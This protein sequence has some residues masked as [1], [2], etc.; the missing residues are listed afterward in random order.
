MLCIKDLEIGH[1]RKSLIERFSTIVEEGSIVS[2]VGDNGV[3]KSTLLKSI[4]S[5]ISPVNGSVEVDNRNL[6]HLSVFEI[7]SYISGVYTSFNMKTDLLV[8]DIL[9]LGLYRKSNLFGSISSEEKDFKKKIVE[10]FNLEKWLSYTCQ[11]IS[12]G[13]LQKV[14]IARTFLQD[15]KIILLDEPFAHLD[16]K[17]RFELMEAL[18]N[19]SV[20]NKKIIIFTSHDWD[21]TLEFSTELWIFN[22]RK[23]IKT[24]PEQYIID[25]SNTFPG[26]SLISGRYSQNKKMLEDLIAFKKEDLILFWTKKYLEK[27]SISMPSSIKIV[28]DI[29]TEKVIWLCDNSKFQCLRTLSNSIK[30]KLKQNDQIQ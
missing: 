27:L 2:I 28:V 7:S 25:Q 9:N 23:I 5:L 4:N 16:Q 18:K 17:N 12:D 6:N 21:M 20:T 29:K 3:G 8:D 15:S 22:N 11:N 13:I 1:N 10:L 24:V 19:E 30:E 26:F 14:L